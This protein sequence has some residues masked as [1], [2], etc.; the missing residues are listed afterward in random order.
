[1]EFRGSRERA[2]QFK[3]EHEYKSLEVFVETARKNIS[4]LVSNGTPGQNRDSADLSSILLN[5]LENNCQATKNEWDE[6]VRANETRFFGPVGPDLDAS[7][8]SSGR[9]LEF[10][11][12][13]VANNLQE[14][15]DQWIGD[16]RKLV[17]TIEHSDAREAWEPDVRNLAISS[18]NKFVETAEEIARS[19]GSKAIAE[20]YRES[21]KKTLEKFTALG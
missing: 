13:I 17:Y 7:L 8:I 19:K 18:L 15:L 16:S 10:R 6:F 1:V 3:D 9:W 11:S 12:A 14:L 5:K 20:H 2:K 21:Y 4:D